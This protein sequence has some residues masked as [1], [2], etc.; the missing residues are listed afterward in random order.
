MSGNRLYKKFILYFIILILSPFV[1]ILTCLLSHSNK[2]QLQNDR[3]A[4]EILASQ[5]I[6]TIEQQV[7][8]AENLCKSVLQNEMLLAFLDKKF[9]TA[10][11][12]SYYTTTI[13][14]FVKVTNGVSD[15]KLRLYLENDTIPMG[16]GIFYPMKYLENIQVIH[17]FYTDD[18]IASLWLDGCYEYHGDV[19]YRPSPK[20][21][22]LYLHKIRSGTR[23]IGIITSIIPKKAFCLSVPNSKT[24]LQPKEFNGYYIYNYGTS[25]LTK[26]QLNSMVTKQSNFDYNR[27]FLYTKYNFEEAP[28]D[29]IIV[30]SRSL[31]NS[32]TPIITI[33][34]VFFFIVLAGLFIIYNHHTLRDFHSCLDGL[35]IAIGDG[36]Q[37]EAGD[38]YIKAI[39]SSR[40][41]EISMLADR[42]E[43]LLEKT[44]SLLWQTVKQQTAEKH[45]QLLALQHQINPHFLYNTMEIFSSRMELNGLYEESAAISAFCRMLRYNINTKEL[46][47][48]LGDE[49]AQVK[50]YLTIQKIRNIPFEI[51][52]D[53]P[54]ELYEEPT[55]RFLLEPFVENSFK[56]RGSANPLCIHLHAVEKNSMIVITISNNGEQIP[57]ERLKELNH[58]FCHAPACLET[59]GDKIGLNNINSRL[60]LFYGDSHYITV[61]SNNDW[62]SF[63]FQVEKRSNMIT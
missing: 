63:R 46:V 56:Y 34:T 3:S 32:L 43:F 54:N 4:N 59:S 51:I 27:D 16:F 7:T 42:I 33:L 57:K 9:E 55:I 12:L 5:T 17:D 29:V 49:L 6:N 25:S 28:F 30:T 15:I 11:D 22:Y 35:E 47:A 1:T 61:S 39:A 19:R 31:T 48:T 8:L 36:F 53:I 14:D 21:T 20:D 13:R 24:V 58:R 2:L 40:N 44:R 37:S 23:T 52:T 62:T 45:A 10:L 60:K 26:K 50:N 41:D 38:N 18:N